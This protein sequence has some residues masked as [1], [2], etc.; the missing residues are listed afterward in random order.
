MQV[1]ISSWR[2]LKLLLRFGMYIGAWLR[3]ARR[4]EFLVHQ[5]PNEIQ[6]TTMIY[7]LVL[8]PYIY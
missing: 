6:T 3:L 8:F 2:V 5:K 1:R 7:C 4:A